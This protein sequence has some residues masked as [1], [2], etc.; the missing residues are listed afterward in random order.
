MKTALLLL[1]ALV[2][3]NYAGATTSA[4]SISVC[5]LQENGARFL[6][7]TIEVHGWLIEGGEYPLIH[8]RK[9]SF[10]YAYASNPMFGG[11]YPVTHDVQWVQMRHFL[12][13]PNCPPSNIRMVSAKVTGIVVRMPAT[14]KI[15]ENEMPLELIVQ[16]ASE[17]FFLTPICPSASKAHQQN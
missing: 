10:R 3:S 13:K 2:F 15:T 6:N 9:C 16:A 1:S 4:Q 5:T 17:V 11:R 7:M 14:G 12:S 8:N